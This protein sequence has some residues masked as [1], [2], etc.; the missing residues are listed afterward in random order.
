MSRECEEG[1]KEDQ[2]DVKNGKRKQ[3]KVD[4]SGEQKS[5]NKFC[6]RQAM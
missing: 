5:E 3:Q 1:R 4:E 6:K 2:D